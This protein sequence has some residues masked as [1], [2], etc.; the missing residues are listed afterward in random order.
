MIGA[1]VEALYAASHANEIL[2][3][4]Y[5]NGASRKVYA[6][7]LISGAYLAAVVA[8]AKTLAIKRELAGAEGGISTSLLLEAVA[9]AGREQ[10]EL[11]ASTD[12]EGWLR[13]LGER[14]VMVRSVK[15]AKH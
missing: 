10:E 6:S 13:Q 8:R 1:T 12:S 11:N 5:V 14:P 2:E 7:E 9:Q 3:I 4:T 15:R